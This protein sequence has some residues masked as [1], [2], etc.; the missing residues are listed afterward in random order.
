M[1]KPFYQSKT[2]WFNIIAVV[3]FVATSQGYADFVPDLELMALAAAVLN[4]V[5][6]AFTKSPLSLRR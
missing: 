2:L 4:V 3:V 1:S 6:R 5:L